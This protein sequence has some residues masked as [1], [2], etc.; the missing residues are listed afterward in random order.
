MST[1]YRHKVALELQ[2]KN[3]AQKYSNSTK[4]AWVAIG[5]T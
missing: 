1:Y 3:Y 2:S 5:K 4:S